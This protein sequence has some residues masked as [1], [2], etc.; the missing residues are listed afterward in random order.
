STWTFLA[1]ATSGRNIFNDSMIPNSASP[2]FL[3][4][5]AEPRSRR[6]REMNENREW[7]I[8]HF[9]FRFNISVLCTFMSDGR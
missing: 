4:E 6:I 1:E 3:K 5:V 9:L 7:R 2:P 8:L